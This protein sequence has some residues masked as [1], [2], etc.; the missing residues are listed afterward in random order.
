MFRMVSLNFRASLG[1][2]GDFWSALLGWWLDLERSEDFLCKNDQLSGLSLLHVDVLDM[3]LTW[4]K[5]N[6][7]RLCVTLTSLVDKLKVSKSRLLLG[8]FSLP[9]PWLNISITF[10]LMGG[11]RRAT[12]RRWRC[13]GQTAKATV[14]RPWNEVLNGVLLGH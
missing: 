3:S 11:D 5:T 12:L 1:E 13:L 14:G 7:C 2:R 4:A 8:V 9:F 6:L 10:A